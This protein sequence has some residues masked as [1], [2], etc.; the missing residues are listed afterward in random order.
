M[1]YCSR[2]VFVGWRELDYSARNAIAVRNMCIRVKR[3]PQITFEDSLIASPPSPTPYHTDPRAQ[4][5]DLFLIA[6]VEDVVLFISLEAVIAGAIHHVD[7][8]S[9]QEEVLFRMLIGVF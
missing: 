6:R 9:I 4:C 5:L 7:A 8:L 3:G 2:L 1:P